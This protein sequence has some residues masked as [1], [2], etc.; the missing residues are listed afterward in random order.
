MSQ[1]VTWQQMMTKPFFL[2]A[3]FI[4][5]FC[6]PNNTV[7]FHAVEP[8]M[9]VPNTDF[10]D[11]TVVYVGNCSKTS[12][13]HPRARL[14]SLENKI[15]TWVGEP[16]NYNA[17]SA[18]G[19]IYAVD[20][21]NIEKSS[22]DSIEQSNIK[23]SN[24]AEP[25]HL[26]EIKTL[27]RINSAT[28]KVQNHF[29]LPSGYSAAHLA[30]GNVKIDQQDRLVLAVL[31]EGDRT[32]DDKINEDQQLLIFDVT[33]PQELKP[34]KLISLKKYLFK[35]TIIP[36]IWRLMDGHWYLAL[37]G[38]HQS[39]VSMLLI[40]LDNFKEFLFLANNPGTDEDGGKQRAKIE[41]KII[42]MTG[43]DLESKGQVTQAWICDDNNNLWQLKLEHGN[44]SSA[45]AFKG[46][47]INHLNKISHINLSNIS[48]STNLA[49]LTSIEKAT[50]T[51][52]SIISNVTNN[53]T[54]IFP[55]IM[56]IQNPAG[57]GILLNIFTHKLSDS[58]I[59]K[60]KI[61]PSE[62]SGDKTS[63][64][65]SENT[66]IRT[67]ALSDLL[68]TSQEKK[69]QLQRTLQNVWVRFGRLIFIF[70]DSK[71]NPQIFSVSNGAW[72]EI[73]RNWQPIEKENL[74]MDTHNVND[75]KIIASQLL[76]DSQ[77]G[78]DILVTLKDTCQL[79]FSA[80]QINNDK[81]GR[82][83]WQRIVPP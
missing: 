7:A 43:L 75:S 4:I 70:E 61:I 21:A 79:S 2:A 64:S 27:Y 30:I 1:W 13:S 57:M 25:N 33:D 52:K 24:K 37:A 63:S 35:A 45:S 60:I 73:I 82:M 83:S 69:I 53:V 11:K 36:K 74:I 8:I 40:S 58:L 46:P 32:T 78:R 14:I 77:N 22:H 29:Q 20:L 72:K 66:E 59:V 6:L 41:G 44:T 26:Q 12:F 71:I 5:F 34:Y 9:W 54:K 76:W 23:Y 48:R 62:G 49:N 80:A 17:N 3:F 67:M 81:Y 50:I 56:T 31:L 19:Y 65:Q 39:N 18:R 42:A 10:N 16:E 51:D 68:I 28:S 38:N 47:N 55:K 15:F